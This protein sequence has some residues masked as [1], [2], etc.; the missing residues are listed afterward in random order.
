MEKEEETTV[1]TFLSLIGVEWCSFVATPST[2]HS[3]LIT[4]STLYSQ[5]FYNI[6]QSMP[7]D[8][9]TSTC[10]GYVCNLFVFYNLQKIRGCPST[11]THNT[12][13]HHCCYAYSPFRKSPRSNDTRIGTYNSFCFVSSNSKHVEHNS[14]RSISTL[15]IRMASVALFRRRSSKALLILCHRTA[16]IS[17]LQFVQFGIKPGALG[18][19]R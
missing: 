2:C 17:F 5:D 12:H 1:S 6:Q 18:L 19:S 14:P 16:T 11:H 8:I 3:H 15:A 10:T 7:M 13:T 4:P 9:S